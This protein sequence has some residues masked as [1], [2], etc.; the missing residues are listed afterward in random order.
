MRQSRTTLK[1]LTAAYRAVLRYG[2]LCNAIALGLIG[3]PVYAETITGRQ[4]L[5][6]DT[7]LNSPV[8]SGI[9]NNKVGGVFWSGRQLTINGGTFENN[10]S[11][12]AAVL[13]DGSL[14]AYGEG[15]SHSVTIN[16]S[17]ITGNQAGDFGA[18][19]IFSPDSS[20][21]NTTFTGN[22][23]T[24]DY[25]NLG[26]GAGA[27]FLGSES[28]TVV[29][30][31]TFT[32]NTSGTIGGAIATR[33]IN[34]WLDTDYSGKGTNSSV[35]GKMDVVSSTFT[36]NE[37]GTRGG[38]IFNSFYNSENHAGSAYI[39]DSTF[40]E[41]SANKGGAVFNEGWQDAAGNYANLY[42]KDSEFEGNTA[43]TSGGAV[44]NESTMTIDEGSFTGNTATQYGGAIYNSGVLTLNNVSVDHNTGVYGGAIENI[45]ENAALTINGGTFE[46][47]IGTSGSGAIDVD[48]GA[49]LNI[50]TGTTFAHNS[51]NASNGGALGL[52]G[53]AT[54]TIDGA[55]FE[56]NTAAGDDGGGAIFGNGAVVNVKNS[57]FVGNETETRAGAISIFGTLNVTNSMF[58]GNITGKQGGGAIFNYLGS[59]GGVNIKGGTIKNT[60][61]GA[62]GAVMLLSRNATSVIDGTLFKDNYTT[63]N[64]AENYIAEDAGGGAL[65]LG[66]ESRV[67]VMNA[68]FDGNTTTLEGG[69]ISTRNTAQNNTKERL[70]I[71]NSTFTGNKAG[72]LKDGTASDL[73]AE[74]GRGGALYANVWH[75]AEGNEGAKIS[76]STFTSNSAIEGGAIYNDAAAGKVGNLIISDSNFTNNTATTAGGALYNKGILTFDKIT[77]F[78]G[79]VAGDKGGAIYNDTGATITFLDSAYMGDNFATS[80]AGDAIYNLG[81]INVNAAAG[82]VLTMALGNKS[83]EGIIVDGDSEAKGNINLN[84]LGTVRFETGTVKNQNINVNSGELAL[85]GYADLYDSST[86]VNVASGAI[87]NSQDNAI[88]DYSSQITL[89]SGAKVVADA[90]SS[91]MDKFGVAS[92]N[93]V[94][95]S[96]LKMLSDLATDDP[97]DRNL[98]TAGN[99]TIDPLLKVYTT[100]NKYAVTGNIADSGKITITKDGLGGL[101]AAV[102]GTDAGSQETV[103]YA[104]TGAVDDTTV[105]SDVEIKK[106]DFTLLGAGTEVGDTGIALNGKLAVDENSSLSV[107]NAK[108][109]GTGSIDNAKEFGATESIIDVNVNN[110][111]DATITRSEFAAGNTFNNAAGATTILLNSHIRGTFNNY[112]IVHSDPTTISGLYNNVGYTD[113]DNDTFDA[114]A[115]LHNTGTVDLKNSVTFDAGAQI[116]GDGEISLVSGTTHFNN[117]ASSNT[118]K[119]ASGAKF[120]GTLASTGVLDT[121]NGN[122]ETAGDLGTVTGGDLYVDVNTTA[123]TIDTFAATTGAN[124]KGIR[125]ANA[126]YGASNKVE[127]DFGGATLDSNLEVEGMNY[128]TNIT[129]DG[130]KIV[131][132]DKLINESNL[133]TKLGSWTGGTYIKTNSDMTNAADGTT[134]LNVGQALTALDTAVGNMSGFGSNTYATST[135]SVAANLAALDTA[136][137]GLDEIKAGV[138]GNGA[139]VAVEQGATNAAEMSADLTVGSTLYTTNVKTNA[140]N[141]QVKI[142][143]DY[144]SDTADNTNP[145]KEASIVA[146]IDG[147]NNGVIEMSGDTISLTGATTVTGPFS[148]TGNATFGGTLTAG[149]TT[150]DSLVINGST[151]MTGVDTV[152]TSGNTTK[153]ITSDAVYTGLAGK[154]DKLMNNAGTPAAISSTVLTS[155]NATPASASDTALVTE[156]AISTALAGKQATISDSDTIIADGSSLIVKSGSIGTTQLAS[157]V[158]TSLGKADD[159]YAAAITNKTTAVASGNDNLITSAGVYANAK[160]ASYNTTAT[161]N[162]A[163][164]STIGG[165]IAAL[166]TAIGDRQYVTNGYTGSLLSN[167]QTIADS[168]KAIAEQTDTNTTGIADIL[169]GD[170]VF[171]GLTMV[172]NAATPANVTMTA[173]DNGDYRD[174]SVTTFA[175]TKTVETALTNADTALKAADNTWTGTNTFNHSEDAGGSGV[176][177]FSATATDTNASGSTASIALNSKT[178][179]AVTGNESVSGDMSVGGAL[180]TTGN[181]TIGGTATIGAANAITGTADTLNMGANAL[182]NVASITTTGAAT[183]G[184]NTS[185]GGTLGVTGATTLGS[186]LQFGAG[187]AVTGIDNNGTNVSSEVAQATRQGTLATAE[188]VYAGAKNASYNTAAGTNI[189]ANSTIGGAINAL[190]TAIGDRSDYSEQNYIAN[191]QTVAASLDALDVAAKDNADKNVVQDTALT[192]LYTALNGGTY[193]VSDASVTGGATI[194]DQLLQNSRSIDSTKSVVENFNTLVSAVDASEGRISYLE[195]HMISNDAEGTFTHKVIDADANTITHIKVSNLDGSAVSNEITANGDASK[196]ATDKAVRDAIN[197]GAVAGENYAAGTTVVD[198]VKSIDANMGKIHGLVASADATTTASGDDYHGNLA[199]GTTIEDHLVALDAAIGDMRGFGTNKNATNTESVAANLTALDSAIGDVNYAD[200]AAVDGSYLATS[201]GATTTVRGAL[202]A[203]DTAVQT[204]QDAIVDSD[205]IVADGAGGL[206]VKDASVGATQ[207]N[208]TVNASLA[209]ADTAVQTITTGETNGTI[210]VDGTDVAVAGLGS[211]AYADTTAFDLAGAATTAQNNAMAYTDTQLSLV[212]AATL[213]D[214]NAYTDQRVEALDKN[215]SAGVAGAV[216]LSSVAVSGVERGEVSVGAGYGYFN[217]QSAAA[218]GAAMGL[219]NRWSINAGAGVSNADVS[220]R[221]GTNYK[222]KLF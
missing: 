140:T 68:T 47:N 87:L 109:A 73:A 94:T 93:T 208:S 196:L 132:S 22:H 164:N 113:F 43:T 169:D 82:K 179:F 80:G 67:K 168:I 111:G 101:S 48:E 91:S 204:K 201:T 17:T 27:L 16:D 159:A 10:Q 24:A 149:A 84:G 63:F 166:D 209:K 69:A 138:E 206:K 52:W 44:Y 89:A 120:D 217:G 7:V 172:N 102:T 202:D 85:D 213:A 103:N 37:A 60:E 160:N 182:T 162:I 12:A 178:G 49:T 2:I 78:N 150:V 5:E 122:I 30:G 143:A 115:E 184:G 62:G 170:S 210:A 205:T 53:G 45:G 20:V 212:R 177:G 57:T 119:L 66:S 19:A 173:I 46:H 207:L 186:S 90:D 155:I 23:A 41:N 21:T 59:T 153:L 131:F 72:V 151:A 190:D 128:F 54:A 148:V 200:E 147:E 161:D 133:D 105:T 117:T 13:Y 112:G 194:A 9:V 4:V 88:N 167:G 144:D 188:T 98:A 42:I 181:A 99:V 32:E 136:I 220:F 108:I 127:L 218:F 214:A 222:F 25:A 96:G 198:A 125:L 193:N 197:M 36:G 139:H 26:D 129:K 71:L 121:R 158:V 81:T 185:V 130:D 163:A 77:H 187:Q 137:A 76:G 156:K 58:D 15:K 79:N 189:A 83:G 31:S 75:D 3:G 165:A 61:T 14:V 215:L 56:R 180:D 146:K 183:L 18:V 174:Q 142:V 6:E 74:H 1:E 34:Y 86:H 28:Q 176:T 175:T 100:A 11:G 116:T 219:T 123:G 33:P 118:L 192:N 55:T 221:A 154:Q 95:L 8:A 157:G 216:A 203:L 106:A 145:I 92:G 152:A 191:N 65:F 199:V 124:V 126:G 211:A 70:S 64:D 50:N 104:V 38:A 40:T 29:T 51:A 35:G 114:T 97:E 171:T 195:S 141:K 134:Y 107:E 39:G 135:T 110:S